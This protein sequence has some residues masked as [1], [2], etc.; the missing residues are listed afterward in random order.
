MQEKIDIESRSTFI[1]E[2][3]NELHLQKQAF[4]ETIERT[5]E[6]NKNIKEKYKILIQQLENSQNKLK[7]YI[8]L[9]ENELQQNLEKELFK[10][11]EEIRKIEFEKNDLNMKIQFLVEEMDRLKFQ[12]DNQ[13]VS[14]Q[15]NE[16]QKE[17]LGFLIEEERNKFNYDLEE[18]NNYKNNMNNL[19]EKIQSL[20]QKNTKLILEKENLIGNK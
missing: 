6:E 5:N 1:S 4:E 7:S 12:L 17:E 11:D 10:K 9:N 19:L 18:I 14:L 15:Y 2:K 8:E 3:N 13:K 16:G 20:D